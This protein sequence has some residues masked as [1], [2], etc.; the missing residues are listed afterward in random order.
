MVPVKPAE[1]PGRGVTARAARRQLL[2]FDDLVGAQQNRLRDRQAERLGGLEID[3]QLEFGRLLDRK[4]GGL[5]DFEDLSDVD[6]RQTKGAREARS[7]LI[8]PPA[9]ANS[10]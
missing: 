7:V 3:H 8:N 6:A 4:I 1:N 9:T 10:L 2:S 5:G